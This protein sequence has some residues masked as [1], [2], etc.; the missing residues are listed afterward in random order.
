SRAGLGTRL[1]LTITGGR[2]GR[3]PRPG[4]ARS[5][6]GARQAGTLSRRQR[7]LA[8]GVT[9][10]AGVPAAVSRGARTAAWS[11]LTGGRSRHDA[12]DL[13]LERTPVGLSGDEGGDDIADFG[14]PAERLSM[15]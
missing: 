3:R 5:G 12:R 14:E 6:R 7:R 11:A 15:P 2:A 13:V 4:S 8:L 9:V 1:V 10:T